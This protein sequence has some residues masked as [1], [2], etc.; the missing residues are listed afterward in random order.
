MEKLFK[1]NN[2]LSPKTSW[3]ITLGGFIF[4]VIIWYLLT[5]G[6]G[7]KTLDYK[8]K[9]D[10]VTDSLGM[11]G[12]PIV[13]VDHDTMYCKSDAS[14]FQWY[15]N[16]LEAEGVSGNHIWMKEEG[17]YYVTV[18]DRN[19]KTF[20]SDTIVASFANSRFID[21]GII[22]SPGEVLSSY[23]EL[24]T[25]DALVRNTFYSI[26]LNVTGYIEAII[27]SLV[28]GFIIGLIPFFRGMFSKYVD[29]IRYIPLTAVTGL[30]IAWF[31]IEMNMKIQFL[32]FGIFVYLLPVVV[33]RI[34]EV[35][36]IYTQTAFTLGANAWQTIRNVFWPS[37]SS[38]I[39]DD[40]RVL[41]AISWTYIIVAE[42]VNRDSGVGAMIF[43]AQRQSRLDKVFAIL[44]VIVIVGVLQ[45]MIFKWLDKLFFPYKYV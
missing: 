22:P 44:I 8:I 16:G 29:A 19:G 7:P 28:M 4:L 32:A 25:Q 23:G 36:K 10:F 1:L 43:M 34:D 42:M 6:I 20:S 41:T 31:G 14:R 12:K 37:V 38:R 27:V 18:F 5:A 13:E 21:R 2:K 11:A 26:G 35:D 39:F 24:H 45:D 3:T 15:F 33:Q 9:Q 40:I 30:F 17:K